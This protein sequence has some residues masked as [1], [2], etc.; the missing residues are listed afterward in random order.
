MIYLILSTLPI[1]SLSSVFAMFVL[2]SIFSA[3]YQPQWQ[4]VEVQIFV[5]GADNCS[6][7][8]YRSYFCLFPQHIRPGVD[9]NVSVTMYKPGL[10]NLSVE[11]VGETSGSLL[12]SKTLHVDGS[13]QQGSMINLYLDAFLLSMEPVDLD[14]RAVC[15]LLIYMFVIAQCN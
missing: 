11:V 13:Q 2:M 1:T 10:V 3:P 9:F 6:I 5:F 14:S 8:Q 15:F 4:T 12:V 7:F